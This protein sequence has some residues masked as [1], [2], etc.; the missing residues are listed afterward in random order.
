[1]ANPLACAAANASLDLFERQDWQADVGRIAQALAEG[2]APCRGAPGVVDVRVKG[3]IGVV[4]FDHV[5]AAGEL[6]RLF[7]DEGV[8]IRPMG[9]VIYLTPAL[10]IEDREL[11]QLTDAVT[12]VVRR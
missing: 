6:C 2:L 10:V 12:S 8:W 11:M 7:A 5:V 1:M 9:G 4:E 3:A